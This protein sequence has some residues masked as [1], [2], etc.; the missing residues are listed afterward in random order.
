M[1]LNKY[2]KRFKKLEKNNIIKI[3]SITKLD[4]NGANYGIDFNII[5]NDK[6]PNDIKK[7][8]NVNL[9]KNCNLI[10]YSIFI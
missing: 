1:F 5:N 10:N 9:D 7:Y 8:M 3:N 6:L 2:I 4:G